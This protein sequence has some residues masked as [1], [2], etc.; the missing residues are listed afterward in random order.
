MQA[1]KQAA[2]ALPMR[3]SVQSFYAACSAKQ[4]AC[5]M[6]PGDLC[7]FDDDRPLPVVRDAIID[8]MRACLDQS[9][10]P[11]IS[12]CLRQRAGDARLLLAGFPVLIKVSW[13]DAP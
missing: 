7:A 4:A 5:A 3:A 1:R 9:C 11:A 6:V 2:A 12:A 8:E 10:A 13:P